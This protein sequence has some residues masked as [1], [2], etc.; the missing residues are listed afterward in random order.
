MR[1]PAF[2]IMLR[3]AR[4]LPLLL[5]LCACSTEKKVEEN[6]LPTDYKPRI[7]E[8][9]HRDLDDP[10]EIRNAAIAE[11]ALKPVGGVTRYVVC[12][13]FE[14]KDA[15]GRYAGTREMAAVYHDG[16]M[17]QLVGA[18]REQ[19]GG[20]VY[21]PFPELQRLCRLMPCPY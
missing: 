21:Q 4:V 8:E 13:R 15:S 18:T 7:L 6:R 10:T 12:V 2:P 20:A 11:P 1:M 19:C 3:Q 17:T 14:P 5:T 9:V 16:K